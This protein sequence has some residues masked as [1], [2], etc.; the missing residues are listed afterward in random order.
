MTSQQPY[1]PP[2]PEPFARLFAE[3]GL[4]LMGLAPVIPDDT[5]AG[6]KEEEYRQWIERGYQGSMQYMERHLHGKYQPDMMLPG[7]RSILVAGLNYYQHAPELPA[8]AGRIARYAWGR[9]YH[10]TLGKRLL[11]IRKRLQELYPDEGFRNFTDAT[12]LSERHY[13][14]LAGIGFQGRNT[15][16]ISGQF[17]SWFVLGEILTTLDLGELQPNPAR[18]EHGNRH[19]ACP[20]SCTRCI[21][22]CPTGALYA[23]HRIDAS[24]CISYLTIEHKGSIPEELR[25][26]MGGWIFGCDLC[27]EVC[28]LN[29][30][31]QVTRET[32]FLEARAGSHQDLAEILYLQDDDAFLARYAGSPLM[33]TGRVG[34][35][36]NACIAAA[37]LKITELLPRLRELAAGEDEIIAEHAAWAVARL[38]AQLSEDKE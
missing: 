18:G 37:N 25:P 11:R 4:E 6:Q 20:R 12:P 34:L 33:R 29:I 22:V 13:A 31:R 8:G 35:M 2:V 10:K 1:F 23:S 21:D 5:A 15:L 28:P 32:D 19:G 7:C 9:D 36:R 14:E 16:L 24:R 30:R 27:Q 17:G 26:Q 3:E 38:S